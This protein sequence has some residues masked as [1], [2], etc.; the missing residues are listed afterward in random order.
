MP[1]DPDT[2]TSPSLMETSPRLT[3]VVLLRI[4]STRIAINVIQI[5]VTSGK[6]EHDHRGLVYLIFYSIDCASHISVRL[7]I[8]RTLSSL[9]TPGSTPGVKFNTDARAPHPAPV[10]PHN[11]TLASGDGMS[12]AHLCRSCT[13]C[14][15]L[16]GHPFDTPAYERLIRRIF[17]LHELPSLIEAISSGEDKSNTADHLYGDDAQTLI[18]VID[19]ARF[20]LASHCDT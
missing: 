18:D 3:G 16:L 9:T 17:V 14:W 20:A 10:D 1:A 8:E 19:E 11:A 6:A 7:E 5:C 15:L 13:T 12:S 4:E 2:T